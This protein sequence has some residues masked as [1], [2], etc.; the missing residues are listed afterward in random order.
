[1]FQRWAM[2][3]ELPCYE[4]SLFT[5]T[6]F[7]PVTSRTNDLWV[8][9]ERWF[10]DGFIPTIE[11]LWNLM[12]YQTL[13]DKELLRLNCVENLPS[14]TDLKNPP[15]SGKTVQWGEALHSCF[16]ILIWCLQRV[17]F[18]DN[19][20]GEKLKQMHRL[21]GKRSQLTKANDEK[22]HE[23]K[24]LENNLHLVKWGSGFWEM[25]CTVVW[26]CL[27]AILK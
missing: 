14:V 25:E 8:S 12:R 21:N 10:L 18:Q 24:F 20:F 5:S 7:D 26:F 3:S 13:F 22:K 11:R 19:F 23:Y 1:M 9:R 15:D 2:A 16:W 27:T 4:K 17:L 6:L